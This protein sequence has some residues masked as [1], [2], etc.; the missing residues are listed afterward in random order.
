MRKK[1]KF[2]NREENKELISE[3]NI[4]QSYKQC[5]Y[6][7]HSPFFV[8]LFITSTI[9]YSTEKMSSS[10]KIKLEKLR[11]ITFF[12]ERTYL[13]EKKIEIRPFKFGNIKEDR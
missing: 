4:M 1:R 9:W 12:T 11:K 2:E 10:E 5:D 8:R 3:I 13:K 6:I 7:F